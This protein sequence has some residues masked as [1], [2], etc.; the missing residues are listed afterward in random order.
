V[1][2]TIEEIV[3][4]HEDRNASL[5]RVF[6]ERKVDLTESR[7]IECHFWTWSGEDANALADTLKT[8]GF[9]I[10]TMRSASIPNDPHRWNVEAAVRQS[11][12]LTMRHEFV[13]ALVRLADSHGGV[14]DGW[15]TRI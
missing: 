4:G 9:E 15:G 3:S 13:E 2:K 1:N 7:L 11:I 12:D 8:Q 5:R 14:Y 6:L 10:V